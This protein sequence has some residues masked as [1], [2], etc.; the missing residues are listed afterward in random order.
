[1][2]QFR[3]AIIEDCDGI[4]LVTVSASHSAFIGAFPEEFIDFSWTPEVSAAN[5]RKAFGKNTDRGQG[6]LVAEENHRLLGFIWAKPW[7]ETAGYDA[8]VQGLYVLPSHHRRGIGRKLIGCAVKKLMPKNLNSLEI[9]CV[10]ENPNCDFYRQLGG[11]EI[12]RR[13]VRVDRYDTE[14]IVFGWQDM[15]IL[16]GN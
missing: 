10:V 15:S 7:A 1:M 3:D 8:C 6:F 11:V 9:G 4:G 16:R 14:E 5:W 2:I 13:P 12:G